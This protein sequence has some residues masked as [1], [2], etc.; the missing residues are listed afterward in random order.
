MFLTTTINQL[1]RSKFI[2]FYLLNGPSGR[3]ANSEWG[4][5]VVASDQPTVAAKRQ[6]AAAHP[7]HADVV[8]GFGARPE[9]G[10]REPGVRGRVCCTIHRDGG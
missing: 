4:R 7:A 9:P 1:L 10:V 5:L 8:R 3:R 6:G 2:Y